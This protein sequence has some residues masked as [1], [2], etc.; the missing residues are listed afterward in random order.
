MISVVCVLKVT[1][2]VIYNCTHNICINNE[3]KLTKY[4]FTL[5]MHNFCIINYFLLFLN[6]LMLFKKL[7]TAICLNKILKKKH[8]SAQC[9][10]T[11]RIL[12]QDIYIGTVRIY[13]LLLFFEGLTMEKSILSLLDYVAL[14]V[15]LLIS[16]S[17][18]IYFRFS[19]GRQKTIQVNKT[20]NFL[21]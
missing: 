16:A 20:C 17:I 15:T 7:L 4:I 3:L 10:R 5:Q 11:S 19:G 21:N 9:F 1:F 13:I 12:Q 8:L 2:I 14:T 18:G 6:E